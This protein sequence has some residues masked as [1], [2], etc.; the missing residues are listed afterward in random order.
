MAPVLVVVGPP[1]SGK[2]TVGEL[3][4]AELG[5]PFR[6]TDADV[7]R[8][9]G[10]SIPDIFIEHGEAHF[11]ALEK[12]AVREALEQHDGVLALGGGARPTTRSRSAPTAATAAAPDAQGGS[13]AA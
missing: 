8:N 12:A 6:D 7:A 9:A 2:S 13:R 11:R 1:G 5:V 4:A 10:A 3:L